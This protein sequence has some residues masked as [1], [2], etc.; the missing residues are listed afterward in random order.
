LAGIP[1][2]PP[3][4]TDRFGRPLRE[5]DQGF[6]SDPARVFPPGGAPRKKSAPEPA[7]P[8]AQRPFPPAPGGPAPF[9]PRCST[10]LSKAPGPTRPFLFGHAPEMDETVF[11][12]GRPPG[13]N[14]PKQVFFQFLVP[15]KGDAPRP[16]PVPPLPLNVPFRGGGPSPP[17]NCGINRPLVPGRRFHGPGPQANAAP[18][19]KPCPGGWKKFCRPPAPRSRRFRPPINPLSR[20]HNGA[21]LTIVR[22]P[23]DTGNKVPLAEVPGEFSGSPAV[24]PAHFGR[25]FPPRPT[26]NGNGPPAPPVAAPGP[27]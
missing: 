7:F 25:F 19:I 24:V 14:S 10:K 5:I 15:T 16:A 23:W 13:P 6:V 26:K 8:P 11:F 21:G 20:D 17:G 9:C 18:P 4:L 27:P 22:G 3:S 2:R 1:P 12:F